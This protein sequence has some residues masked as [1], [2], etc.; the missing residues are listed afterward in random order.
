MSE[1]LTLA[2]RKNVARE[3]LARSGKRDD[4]IETIL[5]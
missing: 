5:R 1:V 4:T 3:T 2:L